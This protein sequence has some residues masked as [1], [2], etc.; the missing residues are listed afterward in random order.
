MRLLNTRPKEDAASLT[1]ALEAM[2]HEVIPAP[3][4]E[5]EDVDTPLPDL[6]EV[7]A[8][9]ATSA[10]GVRAFARRSDRRDLKV[11]AVGDAT[12]A[13]ATAEG[14][15]QV[16]TASGDVQALAQLVKSAGTPADGALLHIA[17]TKVAGD[18]SGELTAAGYDVARCVLYR[19]APANELPETL[20]KGLMAGDV[21]GVLLYSPRTAATLVALVHKA[22][23]EKA[24]ATADVWC[25]SP[26]VADR[27]RDL[28][29]RNIYTA[30]RPEQAALLE[31]MANQASGEI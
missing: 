13:C 7:G 25:L 14:F 9:L 4:L 29:W 11:Y 10:N 6:A 5:I 31:L 20:K 21:D 17:G 3:L 22:G 26:A 27:V 30:P 19:A 15:A 23:L 12:A 1:L 2:G 24:C 18:L 28:E 8:L 16:S